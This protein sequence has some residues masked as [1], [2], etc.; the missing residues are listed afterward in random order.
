MSDD[1]TAFEALLANKHATL[2]DL[3][4][5][6]FA[7]G[8]LAH[9]AGLGFHENPHRAHWL[10]VKRLS[11]AMGWNERAIQHRDDPDDPPFRP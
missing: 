5:D 10:S 2:R 4:I 9:R 11:W 6:A 3:D 7:D 8:V 1:E